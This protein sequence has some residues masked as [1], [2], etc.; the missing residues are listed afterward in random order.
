MIIEQYSPPNVRFTHYIDYEFRSDPWI[1]KYQIRFLDWRE[2]V[3]KSIRS[4]IVS[5]GIAIIITLFILLL[6]I[7][8]LDRYLSPSRYS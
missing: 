3:A 2:R 4:I 5:I 7:D 6:T 1:L 8:A